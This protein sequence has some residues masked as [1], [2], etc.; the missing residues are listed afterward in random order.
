MAFGQGEHTGRSQHGLIRQMSFSSFTL[1]M[2]V[3]HHRTFFPKKTMFSF[4]CSARLLLPSQLWFLRIPVVNSIVCLPI[5]I[6]PHAFL[7][8]STVLGYTGTFPMKFSVF[9]KVLYLI[10]VFDLI[11]G[12][13]L[14]Q[15]TKWVLSRLGSHRLWM[16]LGHTWCC[17]CLVF[18]FSSSLLTFSSYVPSF[19][20]STF[21]ILR[22]IVKQNS[23]PRYCIYL[24][25]WNLTHV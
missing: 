2:P 1:G 9:W 8:P 10:G 18:C 16:H 12:V 25:G 4:F 21:F 3:E 7:K 15:S 22:W 14:S 24:P 19:I 17:H 20:L 13:C 6:L 23:M 11:C 5:K